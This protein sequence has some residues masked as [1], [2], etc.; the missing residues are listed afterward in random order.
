MKKLKFKKHKNQDNIEWFQAEIPKLKWEM[1]VENWDEGWNAYFFSG[2]GCEDEL[3]NKKPLKTKED[4]I[5]F[6]QNY[7]DKIIKYLEPYK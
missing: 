1:T 6:C 4:A 3:L 7:L 2:Y 5:K